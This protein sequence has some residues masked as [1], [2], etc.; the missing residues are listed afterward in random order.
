MTGS[1][2]TAK[3]EKARPMQA[4]TMVSPNQWQWTYTRP[5]MV[6]GRI[7]RTGSGLPK[8]RYTQ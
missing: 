3:E 8:K 7:V 6:K 5:H 2:V 1:L 4:P